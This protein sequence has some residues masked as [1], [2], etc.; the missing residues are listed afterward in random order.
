MEFF[1][2][3]VCVSGGLNIVARQSGASKG[4]RLKSEWH[5]K[6]CYADSCGCVHEV[7]SIFNV[8]CACFISLHHRTEGNLL[9]HV[10]RPAMLL[11]LNVSITRYS[12]FTQ[13][14]CGSNSCI[15]MFY[16]SRYFWTALEATL[17]MMLKTGLVPLL[18][19]YMMFTL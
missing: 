10:V 19:K 6:T 9:S 15:L 13:M 14:L 5:F 4:T 18:V 11:F 8:N 7:L 16:S 1:P 3:L 12:A 2:Q 17:S